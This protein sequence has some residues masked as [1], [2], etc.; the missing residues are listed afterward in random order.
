M[1]G[2]FGVELARH[3][4]VVLRSNSGAFVD[5]LSAAGFVGDASTKSLPAWVYKLPRSQKKALVEGYIAAD[6]HMRPGTKPVDHECQPLSPG[7]GPAAFDIGRPQPTKISKWSRRELKPLGKEEKEYT[8]YFLYFLDHELEGAV[9]FVPLAN[10]EYVGEQ[11]PTTSR[12]KG[13]PTSSPMASSP[14]TAA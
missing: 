9:H 11:S 8:T 2:L 14:T 6:G 7:A 10:I 13:R 12:S 4:G 3:R 5:W 1:R